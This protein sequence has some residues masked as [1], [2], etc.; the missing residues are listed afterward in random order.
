[1]IRRVLAG[2]V[3]V[4]LL[5]GF[6]ALA[7]GPAG[8]HSLPVSSEP[9]DGSTVT[10]GPARASVT[11]N[12]NLQASFPSLTV[13]GPDGNLWSHGDVVVDGPTVSVAVGDLGPTGK[14]T[15]A[16]RV[17]S[18]D[19]HPVSGTRTFTLTVAGHGTP[20]P[21]PGAA[22][23][24]EGGSGGVPVWVFIAAAAVLFGGGLAVVLLG[25]RGKPR[26]S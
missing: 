2:L 7:A 5:G 10:A 6:A 13:V 15:V 25:G 21:K 17:T 8:A 1:M 24:S 3:A 18:A 16:F 19:G 20:G 9:A 14:Y 12:E 23:G 4:L 22:A 26:R 11:F